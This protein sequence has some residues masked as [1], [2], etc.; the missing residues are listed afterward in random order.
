MKK[1]NERISKLDKKQSL[2]LGTIAILAILVFAVSLT[3][4]NKDSGDNHPHDEAAK[5]AAANEYDREKRERAKPKTD[6]ELDR[7]RE[8]VGKVGPENDS[9]FKT[10]EECLSSVSREQYAEDVDRAKRGDSISSSADT[11]KF[12]ERQEACYQNI[13][14]N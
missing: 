4:M 3:I 7:A 11:T 14:S 5:V 6:E 13:H 2:I 12:K 10:T 8:L 9:K 1:I